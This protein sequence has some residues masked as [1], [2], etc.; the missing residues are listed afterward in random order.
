MIKNYFN[1]SIRSLALFGCIAVSLNGCASSI[2][3]SFHYETSVRGER[4]LEGTFKRQAQVKSLLEA[5]VVENP[6]VALEQ[7]L[8]RADISVRKWGLN[9]F[10]K[11]W[12]RYQVVL[13]ADI[14]R[15]DDAIKCRNVSSDSPV[16]APTLKELLVNDGADLQAELTKLISA[17]VDQVKD[18]P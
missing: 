13:E 5:G 8:P 16:G 14:K 11:D 17:C 2:P 3:H 6:K 10:A 12:V 15:E 9:Y 4:G 18:F 1:P 7:A